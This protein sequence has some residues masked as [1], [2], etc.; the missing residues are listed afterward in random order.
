VRVGGLVVHDEADWLLGSHHWRAGIHVAGS[1]D[2]PVII[3]DPLVESAM[4][5]CAGQAAGACWGQ[6][7]S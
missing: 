3:A 4:R 5:Y 6:A 7:S 2:A 1:S